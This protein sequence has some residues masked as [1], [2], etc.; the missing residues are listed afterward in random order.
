VPLPSA[1]VEKVFPVARLIPNPVGDLVEPIEK[2]ETA[3]HALQAHLTPVGVLPESLE[4][5]AA[6]RVALEALVEGA[7]E[8]RA[9]AVAVATELRGLRE[10]VAR[11]AAAL[12]DGGAGRA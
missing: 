3:I 8:Q 1:G 12:E 10:D 2:I 4:H 5:Q 7:A 11:L 9:T 6:A